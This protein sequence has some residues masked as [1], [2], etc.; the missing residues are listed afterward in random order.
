MV[1]S[2]QKYNNDCFRRYKTGN[3]GSE[4]RL[5]YTIIG[6]TVNLASRLESIAEPDD[7]M[8]SHQTYALVKDIIYCEKRDKIQV[9]GIAYPIQTYRVVD[10]HE[11]VKEQHM[12]LQNDFNEVLEK[13]ASIKS[14]DLG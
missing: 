2:Q 4:D 9:K 6:G 13:M 7:I 12:V 5:D 10:V 3:F 11:K 8:I 14:R 1:Q